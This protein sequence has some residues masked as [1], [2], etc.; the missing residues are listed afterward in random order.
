MPGTG[1]VIYGLAILIPI[2]YFTKD[3]KSFSYKAAFIFLANNYIGPD[4][5]QI[6]VG[7]PFHS[8]LGFL[9][10]AV[11]L[12]AFYS[13]F[14]KFSLVKTGKYKLNWQDDGIREVKWLNSYCLTAAGGISHFFIDQFYHFHKSMMIWPG[15]SISH[16]E[17][18]AWGGEA[19]HVFTALS[20]IGYAVTLIAIVLSYYTMKKGFKQTTKLFILITALIWVFILTLGGETFSGE[21]ELGVSVHTIVYVLIP[22]F[23]IFYAARDIKVNPNTTPDVPKFNR[24]SLI[25]VVALIS[26]LIGAAFLAVSLWAIISPNTF[27][28]LVGKLL[29]KD[30]NEYISILIILVAIFLPLSSFLIIGAIGLI[31]RVQF[32]RVIVIIIYTGLIILAFPFAV[33]LLLNEKDVK[34]QFERKQK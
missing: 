25:T 3:D 30:P 18:L 19:Y 14:S 33:V 7:L 26:I 27:L 10:F 5:S 23:L 2:L 32:C 1:H 22:L 16:D 28:V 31:K 17:M 21:R 29:G 4:A 13:Y 24:N 15:V 12:S 9:I 6:F 20:L 8:I 11:P 34:E